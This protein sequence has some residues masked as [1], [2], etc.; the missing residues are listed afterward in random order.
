MVSTNHEASG[1]IIPD[2]AKE[3]SQVGEVVAVGAGRIAH[4]GTLVP[5]SVKK[6]DK[7]LFAKYAG[8]EVD[9]DIIIV[10]E[11]DILGVL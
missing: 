4:D 2:A 9:N 5:M 8:T 3:K 7:V 6:G 10:R 11:D 1:L